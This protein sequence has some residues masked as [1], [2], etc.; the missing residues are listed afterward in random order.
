LGLMAVTRQIYLTPLNMLSKPIIADGKSQ[1]NPGQLLSTE[2][3]GA[4]FRNI[5]LLLFKHQQLLQAIESPG[6]RS[7]GEVL[8]KSVRQCR[9]LP[10]SR[11]S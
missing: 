1:R 3:I 9:P 6:D 4:I 7:F 5:E 8:S 10:P 11:R 2:E